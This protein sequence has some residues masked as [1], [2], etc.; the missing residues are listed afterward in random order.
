MSHARIHSL[1]HGEKNNSVQF[2]NFSAIPMCTVPEGQ[3]L[4]QAKYL[5]PRIHFSFTAF[6]Q[7]GIW[8]Y[9]RKG[10]MLCGVTVTQEM[11]SQMHLPCLVL[12]TQAGTSVMWHVLPAPWTEAAEMQ[13]ATWFLFRQ[14]TKPTRCL[15]QWSRPPQKSVGLPGN[16]AVSG[17]LKL[18]HLR[19]GYTVDIFHAPLGYSQ[20][21]I[22]QA[23]GGC[24]GIPSKTRP[25]VPSAS[26]SRPQSSQIWQPLPP[27]P[28]SLLIHCGSQHL[29]SPLR[30]Q[31]LVLLGPESSWLQSPWSVKPSPVGFTNPLGDSGVHHLP[32]QPFWNPGCCIIGI[33]FLPCVSM[34]SISHCP[35]FSPS[36]HWA[37][38]PFSPAD[39]MTA[40]TRYVVLTVQFSL[41]CTG[42]ETLWKL[43]AHFRSR[44]TKQGINT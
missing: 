3:C 38:G 32:P 41:P 31:W 6:H 7:E 33:W 2:C 39:S 14:W 10:Y 16:A 27:A 17:P 18:P 4:F 19:R 34:V 28:T 24:P 43:T 37:H 20:K 26:W 29:H 11:D 5:I 9:G 13:L 8:L 35:L 25:A 15:P 1:T 30:L 44:Q 22:L 23:Q 40:E 21:E 12:W 36:G 42:A